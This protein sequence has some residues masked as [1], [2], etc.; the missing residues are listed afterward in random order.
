MKKTALNRKV[1]ALMAGTCIVIFS[2][3]FLLFALL[4]Y[5][6]CGRTA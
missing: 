6:R 3:C 1:L 2:F 5:N 4:F